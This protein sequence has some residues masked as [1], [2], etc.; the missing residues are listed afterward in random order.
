MPLL[1]LSSISNP[2]R[3][4]EYFLELTSAIALPC[5]VDGLQNGSQASFTLLYTPGQHCL[6]ARS[7]GRFLSHRVQEE[8]LDH[9]LLDRMM[10]E[11]TDCC[12]PLKAELEVDI[13]A[14]DGGQLNFS[15]SYPGASP[16]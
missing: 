5:R 12:S 8:D 4:R 2:R 3:D 1:E 15:A 16:K 10:G 13:V 11:I 14:P 6:E 7:F 9:A